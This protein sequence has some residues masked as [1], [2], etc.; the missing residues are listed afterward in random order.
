MAIDVQ[1]TIQPQ[2]VATT[3]ALRRGRPAIPQN[4][5]HTGEDNKQS[6]LNQ[7]GIQS[8]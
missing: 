7:S 5:N 2:S 8:I 6:L 3:E 4:Y 1:Q